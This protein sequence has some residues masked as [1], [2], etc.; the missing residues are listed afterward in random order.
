MVLSSALAVALAVVKGPLGP[1]AV[2]R[3]STAGVPLT[4]GYI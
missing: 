4:T 3:L 2:R 1:V